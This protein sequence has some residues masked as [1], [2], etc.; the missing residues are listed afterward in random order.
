M[1]EGG[2]SKGEIIKEYFD[3][4][5]PQTLIPVLFIGHH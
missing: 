2:I 1:L 4:N 5:P 3:D